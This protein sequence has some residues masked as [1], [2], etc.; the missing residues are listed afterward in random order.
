MAPDSFKTIGRALLLLAMFSFSLSAQ[1]PEWIWHDNHGRPAGDEDVC[2]LR[3]SFTVEAA[4]SR[5]VLTVAADN[6]ATVFLNGKQVAVNRS[7]ENATSAS[8]AKE[9]KPG[10]NI[11]A[12]RGVNEGGAAGVIARL[13]LSFSGNQ[14][15][16]VVTDT[17]WVS[18][19]N[20]AAGWQTTDFAAAGWARTASLGKLGV[21][22]WGEV[23][24]G[25]VATAA[26]SLTLLPGFK[27]ELLRSAQPGEGSWVA[28]TIDPK[29]RL[30]ISPQEG[31]VPM[32][33]VTLSSAGQVAQMENLN[34]TVGAAMG[35]LFAEGSLY[36]N[37]RGP[38]GLALYRARY[39]KQTDQFESP[40]A[41]RK[42]KGDGGE[43]GPHGVV[44]GPDKKLYV[45]CGNFVNVP[46]DIL[47]T[48]PH[49]NYADD[50]TLPRMEDGN[51]FGAGKKP[52]GG[53]VARMD[54]DGQNCEL[55]AAGQRNTYDIGFNPDGELFGF[56]SDMEWDWG[57]PW[58][59]PIRLNHIVSGGDYGFREGSAKWPNHYEDSLPTTLDIGIGS[60]TG[61]KFGASA[62]FPEK[63]QKAFFAMDW[64]YGRIVAGHLTP[65]GST[66]TGTWETFVKGKP[67]NVTDLEFGQDG[68]MYFLTGGRGTQA[69][70]YRVSY[71]GEVAKPKKA[72][73]SAEETAAVA[74]RQLRHK[75]ESFHGRKNPEAIDA[76]WPHL[77]SDDRWLRYA[78]R[79]AIESQPVEQWRE[80]ALSEP[81]I[82]A[83]LTALLALARLG[84]TD[85]QT[86]LLE[87][88]EKFKADQMNEEQRLTALRV[89]S[90]S[91]ARMGA[92]TGQLRE[93]LAKGLAPHYPAKS[94]ALNRELSQLMISLN[95]PDVVTTTLALLDA[96]K[97][98]EEQLHYI[99]ALRNLKSGWSISQRRHY[100]DWLN[101]DRK[102]TDGGPTYPGGASY[103]P[104][105]GVHSDTTVQWFKDVGRDYGDGASFQNFMKN[106]RKAAIA[107]LS[108]DEKRDLG[109]VINGPTAVKVAV[110]QRGVVKEWKMDDLVPSLAQA[111]SGRNFQ[112]GKE[113]FAATQCL[114]CHRFGNE[115]GAIG[116]DITAV[117]SRFSRAD[118]LSSIIE[119]SKV[120]SEQYQNT[121]LMLKDDDEVTG[122]VL[123]ENAE[124]LVVLVNPLTGDKK[125]VKKSAVKSR[126]TAKLSPMPEGLVN[127][128]SK[129]EILDLLAYIESA[130]RKEHAAFGGK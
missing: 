39:N 68:A 20:E 106:I 59:R 21:Q 73:P 94:E 72:R 129:E 92:P 85:A 6:R 102:Q 90:V 117:S 70:L 109:E 58:Y 10:E 130:G 52:P 44:I 25:K 4:P 126:A 65:K 36:V 33:R 110:V 84:G 18:A 78:A 87:A 74:A 91:C 60:P 83:G 121:T 12:I 5:A 40:E 41:I 37:G 17:S 75:L 15:K 89:I 61:V 125:E 63:Y 24:K 108:E 111:G 76:A 128:L 32:M 127:V 122:R 101:Q 86:P 104:S 50:V 112:R 69:G 105:K 9:I 30:I 47:P 66:Y 124:R 81:R 2:Y 45:V 97:T 46:E 114:A 96:A 82:N 62:K 107:S 103:F 56:D 55:F 49:R 98:Q 48:S 22:P 67:L 64:S 43:H 51:G 120:V 54:L 95:G 123:E 26:E 14:K 119:P 35:L 13:E 42:W 11:L 88:M 7:W 28:M 31:G 115:G 79:I 16:M 116:P 1:T 3:K 29:G 80:R 34:L 113:A 53:Y 77:N 23:M 27:A 118:V 57:T 93:D 38:E 100:F 99:V 8:V 19:T 71:T